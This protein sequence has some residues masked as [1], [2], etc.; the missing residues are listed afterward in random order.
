MSELYKNKD[1]L[2]QKYWGKK[3]STAE[4]AKLYDVNQRTVGRWLKRLNI[5]IRT[6][7]DSKKLYYSKHP[8]IQKGENSP[9]WN[10][11]GTTIRG[12]KLIYQPNHPYA[13]H[14]GQVL[15]HRLIAEKALG[16]YLKPGEIVHHVNKVV[17]DN[18][19]SNL[20]ICMQGYH[21]WLHKRMRERSK[22]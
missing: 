11:G 3:L 4:I 20:L 7:S 8:G 18:Q 16:R 13:N 10:G 9:S 5:K 21:M 1:W 17:S 2:Y 19:N 12:C 15:E 14:R 22:I 6:N